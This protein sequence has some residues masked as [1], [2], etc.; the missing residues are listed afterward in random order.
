MPDYAD[1]FYTEETVDE[2]ETVEEWDAGYMR[3]EA[4]LERPCRNNASQIKMKALP[5]QS[6]ETSS[7]IRKDII[8]LV[9]PLLKI[10]SLSLA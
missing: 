5:L 2:L 8:K 1:N 10:I 7:F 4:I 3:I 6:R 9:S